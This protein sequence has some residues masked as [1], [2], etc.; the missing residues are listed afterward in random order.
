MFVIKDY[1][2]VFDQTRRFEIKFHIQALIPLLP[3][4]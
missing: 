4:M 1:R 3:N 2:K